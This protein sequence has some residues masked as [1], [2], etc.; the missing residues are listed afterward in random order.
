MFF[1]TVL[2]FITSIKTWKACKQSTLF[3]H[4]EEL[5]ASFVGKLAPR[6]RLFAVLLRDGF[7]LYAVM[8]SS[9]YYRKYL[10]LML[11]CEILALNVTNLVLYTLP[12]SRAALISALIPIVKANFSITG[13]RLILNLREASN[14]R[15]SS[16]SDETK[17]ETSLW[18]VDSE[19][20]ATP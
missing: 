3:S 4:L 17:I 10:K 12:P 14:S 16:S 11:T 7:I 13:S 19:P 6:S 8:L 18:L 2:F 5:T 9:Y 20:V 15:F 1:D